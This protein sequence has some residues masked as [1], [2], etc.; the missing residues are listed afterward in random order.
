[1]SYYALIANLPNIYIGM[2]DPIN[3]KDFF[4]LCVVHLNNHE[5]HILNGVLENDSINEEDHSFLKKW[6]QLNIQIKNNIVKKRAQIR[7]LDPKV[8]I[9]DHTNYSGSVDYS[10]SRALEEKNPADI[11]KKIDQTRF[12]I[13]N[14]L[15]NNDYFS[16]SKILAYAF[17]LKIVL[18]WDS[19]DSDKGYEKL[20]QM[21]LEN[22]ELKEIIIS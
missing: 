7:N 16:L 20:E 3:I 13:L 6:N 5:K 8:Y 10:I 15:I 4:N 17:Q 12:K 2:E 22:T 1:M 14:E 18:K 9:L 21:I 11:E 19:F